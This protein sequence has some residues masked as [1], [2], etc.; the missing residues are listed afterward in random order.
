MAM[1]DQEL[2]DLRKRCLEANLYGHSIALAEDIAE[3]LGYAGEEPPATVKKFSPAHLLHLMKAEKPAAKPAKAA[4]AKK[5]KEDEIPTVPVDVAA[6]KATV[7]AMRKDAAA[8]D[9]SIRDLVKDNKIE[10]ES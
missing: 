3:E 5:V 7:D 8:E 6:V 10:T 2:S 9:A 1:S 4:K